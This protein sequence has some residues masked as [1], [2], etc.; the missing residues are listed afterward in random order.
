M[1]FMTLLIALVATLLIGVILIQN[2]KGGGIDSNFGG[3]Q[4]NQILGA[5][6]SSAIIEKATWYLGGAVFILCI[7]ATYL[8]GGVI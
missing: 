1:I 6:K 8:T 4:S 5:A 3:S 2:P 7:L